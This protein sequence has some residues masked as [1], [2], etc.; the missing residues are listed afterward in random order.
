M[1]DRNLVIGIGEILWDI[2]PDRKVLGG[3]PANFAYHI[4]QWGMNGLIISAVGEDTLGQEAV[5]VLE[6]KKVGYLLQTVG[7]PTGRVTVSLK[8][9]GWPGI[10]LPKMRRG[11]ISLLRIA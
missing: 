2:F 10:D 11:T 6:D 5:R 9:K 8:T 7:S 1:S 4:S 3:A